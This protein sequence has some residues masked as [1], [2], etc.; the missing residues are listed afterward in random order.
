[1]SFANA[2]STMQGNGMVLAIVIILAFAALYLMREPAHAAILSLARVLHGAFRLAAASINRAER[3]LAARNHEVLLAAGR[4]ATEHII[5]REF[6]RM[7]KH[8]TKDLGDC[9]A[10]QRRMNEQIARIEE[11]HQRSTDVPPAPPAWTEA[12]DAVANIPSKGDPMVANILD[13]IHE[14]LVEALE[15]VRVDYRES[16][17]NRHEHLKKM[18][19]AWRELQ[20]HVTTMDKDMLSLLKRAKDIDRH[21]DRYEE[22][23]KGTDRATQTLSSSSLVMFFISGLVLLIAAAGAGINFN[24]IARP[25]A[26]MVGGTNMI[27]AFK[28]ADIA[29]MVIIL[30]ETS[31]GLFLMESLRF[32]RLFPAIGALPDKMRIRLMWVSFSILLGLALVEVGL[33]Y[34]RDILLQD[35]LATHAILREGGEALAGATEF[36]WITTSAQMGIGFVLPFALAFVAIPLEYFVHALRNV[37][38]LALGGIL[39]ALAMLLRIFGNIIR[40]TGK[41]LVDMYDI[42]IFPAIWIERRIIKPANETA[43]RRNRKSAAA[44]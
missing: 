38:G 34:M 39:R 25:M 44:Q 35:E 2:F 15:K 31:M 41:I 3:R 14:S 11:D 36:Q 13:K 9:P 10:L 26:E 37:L 19:P 12:V 1:M 24:L 7:E 27:G 17:K 21:M 32:T 28:V 6:E 29:A 5:E 40:H 16:T 30:V 20:Q 42:V 4:E 8:I 43:P 22:I 33:A 18:R 23:L